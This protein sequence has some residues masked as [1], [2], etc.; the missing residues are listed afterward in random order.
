ME[1]K[2]SAGAEIMQ[3]IT[4]P[5]MLG[6]LQKRQHAYGLKHE[7]EKAVCGCRNLLIKV[8]YSTVYTTSL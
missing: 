4:S 7:L 5:K 3:Y 8:H 1:T 2:H 6:P